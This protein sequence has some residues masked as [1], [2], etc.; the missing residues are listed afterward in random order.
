MGMQQQT[1]NDNS[2]FRQALTNLT[3]GKSAQLDQLNAPYS[4]DANDQSV[5]PELRGTNT[6]FGKYQALQQ[7]S[8]LVK[9]RTDVGAGHDAARVDVAALKPP[10]VAPHITRMVGGQSHIMERDPS[11]GQ[12]SIDR[13]IAPPNYA[14]MGG[15]FRLAPAQL[16]TKNNNAPVTMNVDQLNQANA[17]E[18]GRYIP[19]GVSA[20]ALGKTALIED[21]RGNIGHLRDVLKDPTLPAFSAGQRAKIALTLG[22][23]DKGAIDAMVT[24]EFMGSLNPAQQDYVI[25]LSQLVENSMAMRSVLG[26]GQGSEDLR[27]AIRRT[28]PTAANP[29]AQY[30]GKQLDQ[31]ENVLN[32]L[33][34][35]IPNVPLRG[36]TPANSSAPNSTAAPVASDPFAQFGGKAH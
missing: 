11:T 3:M 36:N 12:Y 10:P 25:G 21:I 15:S 7:V 14:M 27:D 31:F 1:A 5:L 35:G 2:Q 30:S 34:R 6:T 20:P 13:G 16:D 28:I 32:R 22:R 4:I 29:N 26:A 24:G 23:G 8:A 17:T 18:P 19:A 33:E 9:G